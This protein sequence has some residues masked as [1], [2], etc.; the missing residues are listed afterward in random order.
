MPPRKQKPAKVEAP[1]ISPTRMKELE[2]S[3]GTAR[4]SLRSQLLFQSWTIDKSPGSKRVI[5][6]QAGKVTKRK[7]SL[8]RGS[9]EYDTLEIRVGDEL[10]AIVYKYYQE[11]MSQATRDEALKK[12]Q[13]RRGRVEKAGGTEM[14]GWVNGGGYVINYVAGETGIIEKKNE[15]LGPAPMVSGYR[16]LHTSEHEIQ[17][18]WYDGFLQDRWCE[19]ETWDIELEISVN[20]KG[21]ADWTVAQS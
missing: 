12:D 18:L 14:E 4:D 3:K 11:R 1:T 20:V 13:V 17:V 10:N 7:I 16:Y 2:G 15:Y 19:A 5:V 9:K 21:D 6:P 8:P